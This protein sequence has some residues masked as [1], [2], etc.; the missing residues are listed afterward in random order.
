MYDLYITGTT[1][2]VSKLYSPIY[3]EEK[4]FKQIVGLYR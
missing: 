1:I 4:I 3:L 2:K